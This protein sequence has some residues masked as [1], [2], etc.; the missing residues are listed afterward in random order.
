MNT[1]TSATT[2]STVRTQDDFEIFQVR[3][4]LRDFKMSVELFASYGD[5]ILVC[6]KDN[7][8]KQSSL[9]V[10]YEVSS[11]SLDRS[12]RLHKLVKLR[13]KSVKQLETIPALEILLLLADDSVNI[14][15]ADTLSE[16]MTLSNKASLF[17]TR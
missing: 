6:G 4:I 14:L 16:L 11:S 2:A 5:R 8:E 12:I 10:A 9:L 7:H 13:A 3:P 17:A 1:Y 15:D